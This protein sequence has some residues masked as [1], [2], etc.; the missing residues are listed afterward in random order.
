MCF[1]Y[2]TFDSIM[3]LDQKSK[4]QKSGTFRVA[5]LA[6]GAGCPPVSRGDR[7][8]FLSEGMGTSSRRPATFSNK[9]EPFALCG[10]SVWGLNGEKVCRLR[11]KGLWALNIPLAERTERPK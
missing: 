4:S 11:R 1:K 3:K 2:P 10:K 8:W 5:S 6:G 7:C 9:S